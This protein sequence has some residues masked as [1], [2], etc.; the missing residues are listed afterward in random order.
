MS[1]PDR[2]E[3]H[4]AAYVAN[5]VRRGS[6][7]IR[8]LDRL[9]GCLRRAVA[10]IRWFLAKRR[11][12]CLA[13]PRKVIRIGPGDIGGFD[14]DSR[15][16]R[17]GVP[18]AVVGGEWDL[19]AIPIECVMG[20]SNKFAGVRQH[21]VDGLSWTETDLFKQR[22]AR[23]FR[24]G[25]RVRGTKSADELARKYE[26]YDRIFESI[27]DHGIISPDDDP[28]VDPI[29][30]HINRKGELLYTSDGTHR[31]YMAIILGVETIPVRVWW[32][33]AEWQKIREE[34][35][36]LSPEERRRRFPH[37]AGHPDLQDL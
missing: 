18:G 34:F 23:V 37:L 27:R 24:A 9:G 29:Y 7:L 15:I 21:F 20:N 2:P 36:V 26:R 33:H 12:G 32:R 1:A 3:D 11:Y 13:D 31:L 28:S 6:A 17:G 4:D 22:Y 16:M 14:R 25:G 19:T 35:A 30:V 5:A 8:Q 10:G